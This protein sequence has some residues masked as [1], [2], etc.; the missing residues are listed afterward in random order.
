[1]VAAKKIDSRGRLLL[2]EMFAGQYV[3][4]EER[5]NGEFFVKPAAIIPASEKWL[6]QNPKA[7][8]AVRAGLQ[9]ARDGKI[10]PNPAFETD[11]AFIDKLE[12]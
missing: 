4:I 8:A 9:E 3:I 5:G 7:L 1:M 12:D 10:A 2:G 6:Y 11:K